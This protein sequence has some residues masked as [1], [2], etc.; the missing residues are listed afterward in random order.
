MDIRVRVVAAAKKESVDMS[1][2]G[3][4]TIY[5]KAKKERNAA[6]ARARFLLAKYFGVP[7]GAVRLVAGHHRPSKRFVVLLK[8]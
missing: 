8:A 2:I 6:N 3:M 7:E 5:T 4:C 1:D